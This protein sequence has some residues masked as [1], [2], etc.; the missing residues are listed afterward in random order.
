MPWYKINITHGPGHHSRHISYRYFEQPL[1]QA[2]R[3]DL[4]S[5]ELSQQFDWP[6]GSIK[7]VKKLPKEEI[8]NQL[9]RYELDIKRARIMLK[10]LREWCFK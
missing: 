8:E 9:E 1:S 5:Y 4:W 3:R 7:L 2:Q 6:I 10:M